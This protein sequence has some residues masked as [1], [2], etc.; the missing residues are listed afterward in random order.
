VASEADGFFSQLYP[1]T[2]R[3]FGF[4]WW[5]VHRHHLHTGLAEGARRHGVK[6][7]VNARVASI[8]HETSPV[9]VKTVKGAEYEFDFV[10][11]SDGLRSIVRNTLFPDVVPRTATNVAA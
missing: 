7:V 11:G 8:N 6:I 9:R 3:E 4:P 1:K 2:V 10:I 5:M